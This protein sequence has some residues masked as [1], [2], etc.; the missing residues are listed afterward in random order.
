MGSLI[1]KPQFGVAVAVVMLACR[2][3]RVIGGGIA[4][5]AAQ[6]GIPALVFGTGPL[7]AYFEMLK[8]APEIAAG[9]EP[10]MSLLHSLRAFWILLLPGSSMALVLYVLSSAA[11]LFVAVRLWRTSAPLEYRYS[12][13]VL[14]TVLAAPHLGA[15]DSFLLRRPSCSRLRRPRPRPAWTVVCF[16][17]FWTAP[18]L[19]R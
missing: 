2:E 19:C 10:K 11:T 15:Y 4:A 5:V 9:L 12:A 8:K 17:R 18:I 6:W 7:L 1:I 13:L 16:E 3:W 14:A